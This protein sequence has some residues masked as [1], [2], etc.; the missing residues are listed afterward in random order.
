MNTIHIQKAQPTVN[1]VA[2]VTIIID[3][4]IPDMKVRDADEHYNEQASTLYQALKYSLPGGT[5]DRLLALMMT[6]RA[7][8]FVVPL[9]DEESD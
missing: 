2:S 7:S 9:F 8:L 5:Y 4:E 6:D 1:D 3:E